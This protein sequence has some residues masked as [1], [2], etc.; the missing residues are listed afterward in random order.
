M[1][2]SSWPF[3]PDDTTETQYSQIFRNLTM[4]GVVGD[5]STNDLKPFGDSSGMQIKVPVGF[6]FVRGHMY[7]N[8]S[9]LTKAVAAAAT[10]P[11]VDRI[12]LRLDPTNNRITCEVLAGT[13]AASP[14]LPALTQTDAGI[15]EAQIGQIAVGASVSTITA[16][17][18]TDDRVFNSDPFGK[19]WTPQRPTAATGLRRGDAGFNFTTG[20]PEYYDGTNWQPFA[21]AQITANQ[22]SDQQNINAGK[23][24]GRRVTVSNTGA[25]SSPAVG[26]VWIDW[27]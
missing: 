2:E 3:D 19:W 4:T 17:V 22:I 21:P 7:Y 12:V 8:D 26:D 5:P 11:R 18:V 15:Y 13:P 1:A 6:A 14:T 24:S 9:V 20:T 23:I 27:S 25:P 16:A 10:S